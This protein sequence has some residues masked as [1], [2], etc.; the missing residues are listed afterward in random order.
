[1]ELLIAILMFLGMNTNAEQLNNEEYSKNNQ[2][3]IEQ[4]KNIIESNEYKFDEEKKI[5]IIDNGTGDKN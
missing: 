4:A 5:V 3:T 2:T 1:M